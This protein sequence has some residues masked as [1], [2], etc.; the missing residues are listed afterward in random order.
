MKIVINA[1]E[2]IQGVEIYPIISLLIFFAFFLLMNYFVFNLDKGYIN[3]MK[4]MPLEDDQID[5]T[6]DFDNTQNQF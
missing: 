2:R 3:K 6:S 5:D 1:L 4:N